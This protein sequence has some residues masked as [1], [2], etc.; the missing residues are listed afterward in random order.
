MQ[1]EQQ[2]QQAFE[3]K[4]LAAELGTLKPSQRPDLCDF[5]CNGAMA[6]AG[7]LKMKP[8]DLASEIVA[9]LDVPHGSKAE[10]V[11]PGFINVTVSDQWILDQLFSQY[12][13]NA[14]FDGTVVMDFGGAN[15]AKPMHVG[16]LRSLVIGDALSRIAN[17]LGYKVIRD[18]HLGDWGLQMGMLIAT[19]ARPHNLSDLLRLYVNASNRIKEDE[20]FKLSAQE[21]TVALQS[22]ETNAFWTWRKFV[23]LSVESVRKDCQLLGVDFDLWHG[24]S[25]ASKWLDDTLD[26]LGGAVRESEGALVIGEDPPLILKNQTGAWLYGATDLATINARQATY[27]PNEIIY[28]V[29]ERQ[30]LHFKQVFAA[31]QILTGAKLTHVGFGTVNGPDGKPYKTRA[32]G[33]PSLASLLN[34]AIEKASE[35]TDDLESAEKVAI[36]AVKFND[37]QSKRTTNYIFDLDRALSHEGHT[38]V[39]LLYAVTR[40]NSIE[41]KA[42]VAS[43]EPVLNSPLKR[44]IG[45]ALGNFNAVVQNAWASKMPHFICEHLLNLASLFSQLYAQESIGGDAGNLGLALFVRDQLKLGLGLLGIETVQTM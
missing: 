39:Y 3:A 25:D 36:A 1:L 31:G 23:R 12:D 2:I 9:A 34:E 35:R 16:H 28:V 32:G 13:T 43:G 37:L 7:K 10:A 11:A 26:I 44:Q 41:A 19:G 22:G 42:T 21:A 24:E 4:G 40:I 45:L 20:S 14:M 30:A 5:V 27:K 18:I 15:I 33:T 6:G 29:D 17:Y 38:G 8:L